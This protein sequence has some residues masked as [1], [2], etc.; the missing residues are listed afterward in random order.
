LLAPGEAGHT[1]RSGLDLGANPVGY[2][3]FG[4][5]TRRQ[6]RAG[7]TIGDTSFRRHT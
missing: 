6:L 4:A 1:S 2:L 3:M 5:D 7:E